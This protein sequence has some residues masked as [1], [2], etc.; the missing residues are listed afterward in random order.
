M[1]EKEYFETL[2]E[3][4]AF[5]GMEFDELCRMRNAGTFPLAPRAKD[6]TPVYHR[7]DVAKWDKAGR[8]YGPG[9]AK[10]VL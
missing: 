9:W 3:V 5:L 6:S 10:G 7:A 1:A 2:E 8:P 4:A